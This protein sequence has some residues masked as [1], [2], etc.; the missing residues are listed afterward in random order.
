MTDASSSSQAY[1]D[2]LSNLDKLNSRRFDLEAYVGKLQTQL[3]AAREERDAVKVALVE[4][5]LVASN[6]MDYCATL[7]EKVACLEK[8]Y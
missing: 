1:F 7:R 6:M 2:F 5:R 4:A 8:G 3:D